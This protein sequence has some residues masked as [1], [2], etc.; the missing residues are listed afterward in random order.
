MIAAAPPLIWYD[1][2]TS[3]GSLVLPSFLAV[4]MVVAGLRLLFMNMAVREAE[5]TR[6]ARLEQHE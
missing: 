4:S 5:R 6:R 1:F 3:R 2:Q